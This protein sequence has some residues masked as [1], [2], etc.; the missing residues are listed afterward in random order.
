VRWLDRQTLPKADALIAVSEAVREAMLRSRPK[1][2]NRI[3]TVHNGVPLTHGGRKPELR[4]AT[5][6]ELGYAP[7]DFVIGSAARLDPR[8]GLDTLI[9][10]FSLARLHYANLRLLIV[11]DGPERERLEGLVAR[12]ELESQVQLLPNRSPIAPYLMAMDMFA[13]P[14]RTEGLGVALI[15]ALAMGLPIVA[16]N[17]GGIPE[18][19]EDGKCGRLLPPDRI[20]LWAENLSDLVSMRD[21]LDQWSH[22]APRFARRFSLEASSARLAQVYDQLLGEEARGQEA[23]AA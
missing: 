1:L 18:V 16:S 12:F 22:D 7:N 9:E 15:E 11:G 10:A 13:A 19:V 17:V 8:K 5:R 3:V 6:R 4:D 21:V 23:I 2:A 20:D 14:S